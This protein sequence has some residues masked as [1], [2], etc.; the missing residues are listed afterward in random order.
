M[1]NNKIYIGCH[2]TKD[3]NDDYMGS[4]LALRKD[5]DD[6]GIE[7]FHKEI[8]EIF[9]NPIDMFDME[10]KLVDNNFVQRDDTYNLKEG[11][12]GGFDHIHRTQ[13]Y[14]FGM[15]DK[16]HSD[17]TKEKMRQSAKERIMPQVKDITKKKM[18]IA[19]S[20]KN[21]PSFGTMWIFNLELKESKKIPKEDFPIWI[22]KGWLKGRKLK[23]N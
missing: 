5:Q 8:L 22:Q 1:V 19:Q 16:S 4:G 13:N 10:S 21:N 18:S 7:F 17:E 3:I 11:G 9:D 23:F 14:S 6:I 2:K 15:K 12:Y 20:G